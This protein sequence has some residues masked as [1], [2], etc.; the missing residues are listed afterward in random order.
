MTHRLICAIPI[1]CMP[2]ASVAQET[3]PRV[4]D[5]DWSASADNI[6]EPWEAHSRTFSDGKTRLALL[7]TIEPALGW[8]QLLIMS[9]PYDEVG[10]RQCKVIGVES[11]GFSGMAFDKLTASYDPA[12][13]LTFAVPVQAYD[14]RQGDHF[15]WFTLRVT[16]NQASGAI[17]AQL[18]DQ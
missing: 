7:D 18:L 15:G 2:I 9:P 10:G 13:G 16:L 6:V 11:Y 12:S 4:S 14:E 17:T 3:V 1:V 5:C 8:A